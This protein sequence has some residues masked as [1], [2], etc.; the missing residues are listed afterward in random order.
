MNHW[1]YR[2]NSNG[3][4]VNFS[5]ESAKSQTYTITGLTAGST[6]TIYADFRDQSNT[7]W[8]NPKPEVT[9]TLP[10]ISISV[11]TG[12]N[13]T[14]DGNSH[15]GVSEGIGYT[16]GGD[17]TKTSAGDYTA[18][19]T[20]DSQHKWSD[21]TTGVK[22]ITWKINKR[23]ITV[24]ASNQSKTWDGSVLNADGTCEVTA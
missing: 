3:S 22:T 15:T 23:A 17:I 21:G 9:V 13:F 20:L 2:V 18:T 11:P 4:W 12:S 14:Y 7:N 19:A 10:R 5:Y 6:Y 1:Q 24:K 16:L 8:A